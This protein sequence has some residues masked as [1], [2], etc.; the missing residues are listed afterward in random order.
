MTRVVDEDQTD[1]TTQA[2]VQTYHW[3][4]ENPDCE[5]QDSA[6]T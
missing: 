6:T 5:G 2:S 3:E 1:Q 4:C